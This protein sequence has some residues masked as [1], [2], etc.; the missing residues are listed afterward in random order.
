MI[1][2]YILIKI[3]NGYIYYMA[4]AIYEIDGTEDGTF[5]VRTDGSGREFMDRYF[6]EII[7]VN[8][9]LFRCIGATQ[10][11]TD[12]GGGVTRIDAN[13]QK[14][15]Y[16]SC[17]NLYIGSLKPLNNDYFLANGN[18]KTYLVATQEDKCYPLS[19]F[20]IPGLAITKDI[21]KVIAKGGY[22]GAPYRNSPNGKIL[23]T[24]PAGTDVEVLGKSGSNWVKVS[25]NGGEYYVWFDRLKKVK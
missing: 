22:D 11:E 8:G 20:S 12:H 5:R 2:I 19:N 15:T 10:A 24:I 7:S 16:N 18:N 1:I 9:N 3:S 23:G 17:R 14:T 21:Y 25:Y 4:S 13:G 6:D